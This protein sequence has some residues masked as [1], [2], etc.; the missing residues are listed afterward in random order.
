MKSQRRTLRWTKGKLNIKSYETN[1]LDIKDE[2]YHIDLINKNIEETK[3]KKH[4]YR[5]FISETI[6]LKTKYKKP[7]NK[8]KEGLSIFRREILIFFRR[9]G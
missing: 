1:G 4:P 2:E 8:K 5:N 9:N 6:M 7:L 3:E